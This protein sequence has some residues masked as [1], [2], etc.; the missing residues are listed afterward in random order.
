MKQIIEVNNTDELF[1]KL[2]SH[3]MFTCKDSI[4]GLNV[5]YN[6]VFTVIANPIINLIK[7][8]ETQLEVNIFSGAIMILLS[9][10]ITLFFWTIATFAVIQAKLPAPI[11]I[12]TYLLPA[13]IW[14]LQYFFNRRIGRIIIKEITDI[15]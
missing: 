9:V 14:I 6:G 5:R 8:S 7:V 11:S 3:Q 1:D 10:F 13:A 12:I 15:V 4:S 2:K